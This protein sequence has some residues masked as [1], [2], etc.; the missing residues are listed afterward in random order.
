[1]EGGV[2]V[3]SIDKS[4]ALLAYGHAKIYLFVD[5]LT[6]QL[7]SPR[8][9]YKTIRLELPEGGLQ[10]CQAMDRVAIRHADME[11]LLA[12]LVIYHQ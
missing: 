5:D 7:G 8:I 4:S 9:R 6:R 12:E 1:V 10:P 11:E 3:A 2:E